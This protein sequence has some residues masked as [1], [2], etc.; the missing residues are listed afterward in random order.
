MNRPSGT[1]PRLLC[2][3]VALLLVGAIAPAQG[4]RF[5][6]EAAEAVLALLEDQAQGR[7]IGE[8]GWDRLLAAPGYQRLKERE[9]AMGRAFTDEEFRAFVAGPELIARRATLRAT[10]ARWQAADIASARAR[11]AAYLPAGTPIRATVFPMIKP[12]PNSFVFDT[13]GDPAIFLFLD[14]EVTPGQFANT[15]AHELHHIGY[16]AAC[17]DAARPGLSPES[18]ALEQWA[19]AFGEGVAMLAAAG[20]PDAHP[21]VTSGP[22]DRARW[23]RDVANYQA[24]FARL[25]TFFTAIR[26]GRLTDEARTREGMGFFGTQGPWYTVGWRMA[27]LVETE[28]GRAALVGSLCSRRDFLTLYNRAAQRR[29]LP[30]WPQAIIEALPA[31]I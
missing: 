20:G 12:R 23:D 28:F 11:A 18:A 17:S 26:E 19:G 29:S 4:L 7:A 3:L 10:L 9:T 14:P 27:Q 2:A 13:R 6:A 21:H 22:E 16:A 30:L 15:V 24:D 25:V 31:R 8:P 1:L 5:D